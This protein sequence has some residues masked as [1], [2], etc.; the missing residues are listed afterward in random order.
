MSRRFWF[1]SFPI[2]GI[3][4]F[5]P[6]RLCRHPS[7]R[8]LCERFSLGARWV[9]SFQWVLLPDYRPLLCSLREKL[10]QDLVAVT[11]T[12]RSSSATSGKLVRLRRSSLCWC[13]AAVRTP[14]RLPTTDAAAPPTFLP[15]QRPLVSWRFSLLAR[16]ASIPS[17]ADHSLLQRAPECN[18]LPAPASFADTG[19]PLC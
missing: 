13:S 5:E 6:S 16:R 14:R 4:D 3:F 17:A 12:R 19:R 2:H 9:F 10:G 15:R 11:R 1:F 18:A 8:T 7:I